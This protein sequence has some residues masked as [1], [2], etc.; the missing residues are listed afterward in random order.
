MTEGIENDE[1]KQKMEDAI[2]DAIEK[3][4]KVGRLAGRYEQT[5]NSARYALE[6]GYPENAAEDLW[7]LSNAFPSNWPM[8]QAAEAASR[9]AGLKKARTKQGNE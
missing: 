8:F 3:V 5:L 6:D 2:K 7:G 9:A 4:D 1:N